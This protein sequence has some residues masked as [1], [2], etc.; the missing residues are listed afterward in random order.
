MVKGFVSAKAYVWGQQISSISGIFTFFAEGS[1]FIQHLVAG[2]PVPP[3]AQNDPPRFLLNQQSTFLRQRVG[4]PL[5]RHGSYSEHRQKHP[6]VLLWVKHLSVIWL[7]VPW[8][9]MNIYRK[10]LRCTLRFFHIG[11]DK[12]PIDIPFF[13]SIFPFPFRGDVQV[14]R[15]AA[16]PW[17]ACQCRIYISSNS[18]DMGVSQN[19]VYH[20]ISI[21]C[22]FFLSGVIW[23]LTKV[24]LGMPYFQKKQYTCV[25]ILYVYI[26]IYLYRMVLV[27]PSSKL[28]Y[29]PH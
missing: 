2:Y 21:K 17:W 16:L 9:R 13:S 3:L 11:M 15:A 7:T 10:F 22:L 25:N 14:T 26:Y 5:D 1:R 24:E 6:S 23:W 12:W 4:M 28:V 29:K 8:I 27:P 19:G 18:D 20:G